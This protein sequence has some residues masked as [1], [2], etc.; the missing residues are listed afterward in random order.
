MDFV[1]HDRSRYCIAI[2]S[3]GSLRWD[4]ITR[5]VQLFEEGSKTWQSIF[6]EKGDLNQTYLGEWKHFLG[7]IE[8]NTDPKVTVEDGLS[9]L[10]IIEAARI[11]SE[12]GVK[13]RIR[14]NQDV[15]RSIL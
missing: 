3:K 11:S 9:V 12:S 1:R 2:G 4:G 8:K 6:K 10:E 13:I 7:S 14:N 15:T 5:E